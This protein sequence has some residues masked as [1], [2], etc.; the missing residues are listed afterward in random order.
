MKTQQQKI[1]SYIKCEIAKAS[2]VRL[3]DQPGLN[4]VSFL[5]P[6]DE[7]NFCEYSTRSI[8][9]SDKND[10]DKTY[11]EQA[12]T[13]TL[14]GAR[15]STLNL[16]SLNQCVFRLTRS[17]GEQVIVGNNEF[18]V[19]FFIEESGKPIKTIIKFTHKHPES[20]KIFV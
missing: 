17:T 5:Y 8:E 6:E 3:Y 9:F 19:Q 7:K 11:Q 1:A 13:I 10:E 4:T 14:A 20:A 18:P 2:L 12:A 15:D 16:L